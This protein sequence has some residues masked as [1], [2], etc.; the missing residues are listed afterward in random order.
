MIL[1]KEI[2]LRVYC[3][4]ETVET[5]TVGELIHCNECK[6]FGIDYDNEGPCYYCNRLNEYDSGDVLEV[7]EDGYCF[8]AEKAEK[9]Q[10]EEEENEPAWL[11]F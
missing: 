4:G 8:K 1:S 3:D 2:I 11:P 6:Y 5:D 10:K 9:E 7:Y